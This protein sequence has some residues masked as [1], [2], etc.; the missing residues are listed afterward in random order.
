MNGIK[1]VIGQ[2]QGSGLV[3]QKA[4]DQVVAHDAGEHA[5][6]RK[7]W[8]H[9]LHNGVNQPGQTKAKPEYDLGQPGNALVHAD[10]LGAVPPNQPSREWYGNLAN[11][12]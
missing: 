5:C 3:K 7:P 1:Q 11:D 10:D 9:Q 2:V 4:G 6:E 8:E 12:R